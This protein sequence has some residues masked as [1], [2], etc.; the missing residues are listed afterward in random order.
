VT[1]SQQDAI[2]GVVSKLGNPKI[3]VVVANPI[4]ETRDFATKLKPACGPNVTVL[5]ESFLNYFEH[6]IKVMSNDSNAAEEFKAALVNSGV[7]EKGD[8]HTSPPAPGSE[9]GIYVWISSL[10]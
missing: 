10:R 6:G 3:V 7:V 9:A 4:Q 2:T 1:P 8:I 5:E